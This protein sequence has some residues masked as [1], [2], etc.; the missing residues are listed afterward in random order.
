M[1]IQLGID[2]ISQFLIGSAPLKVKQKETVNKI[3]S[4]FSWELYNITNYKTTGVFGNRFSHGKAQEHKQKSQKKTEEQAL[5]FEKHK[6][7][8][9]DFK[10]H[11]NPE[12]L[13]CYTF[14]V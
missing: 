12:D 2:K 8:K 13:T 14:Q 9:S 1:H 5:F 11:P 10:E 4:N 7:N 3:Q 6:Q